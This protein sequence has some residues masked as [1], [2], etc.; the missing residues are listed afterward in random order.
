MKK[1]SAANQLNIT[2]LLASHA[3]ATTDI[4]VFYSHENVSPLFSNLVE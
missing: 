1:K 2:S 3:M 4:A